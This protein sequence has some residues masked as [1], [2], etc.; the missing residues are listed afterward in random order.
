M[1]GRGGGGGFGGSCS[2]VDARANGHEAHTAPFLV[3]AV[4]VLYKQD[5]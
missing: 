1:D 3:R 2:V 4:E 5:I